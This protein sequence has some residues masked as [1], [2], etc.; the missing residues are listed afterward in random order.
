MFSNP[1]IRLPQDQYRNRK[2]FNRIK[3]RIQERTATAERFRDCSTQ[4]ELVSF[5]ASLLENP[6][7]V[8]GHSEADME[9][10]ATP[11]GSARTI[12]FKTFKPV[13]TPKTLG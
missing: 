6:E 3:E 7:Y 9:D 13:H 8:S 10:A 4:T 11:A 5:P 2:G 12:A 1:K